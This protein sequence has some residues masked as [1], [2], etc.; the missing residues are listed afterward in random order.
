MWSFRR[1]KAWKPVDPILTELPFANWLNEDIAYVSQAIRIH[2]QRDSD[3]FRRFARIA[4]NTLRS[5]AVVELVA[6]AIEKSMNPGH[7]PDRPVEGSHYMRGMPHW[8]VWLEVARPAV[9][10]IVKPK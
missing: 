4:L 6:R 5:P 9:K 2:G 3:G 8:C 7:N 1:R 10:A